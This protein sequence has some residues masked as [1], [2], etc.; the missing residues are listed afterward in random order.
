MTTLS[1]QKK[2]LP[3]SESAQRRYGNGCVMSVPSGLGNSLPDAAAIGS[4][5]LAT[6]S[7]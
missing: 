4:F 1:A 2:P 5:N 6:L 7:I 3:S